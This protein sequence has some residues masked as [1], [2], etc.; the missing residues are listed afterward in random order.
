[1]KE[2]KLHIVEG[3]YGRLKGISSILEVDLDKVI[4][5]SLLAGFNRYWNPICKV[6]SEFP[7]WEMPK[8][9]KDLKVQKIWYY[10]AQQL[11]TDL[12]NIKEIEVLGENFD[13]IYPDEEFKNPLMKHKEFL[14]FINSL[15]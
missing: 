1:M 14:K 15:D 13:E 4:N 8:Q 6:I 3:I 2:V 5:V 10:L 12:K 11:E 7:E 9:A